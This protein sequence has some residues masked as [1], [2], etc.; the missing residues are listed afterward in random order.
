[1]DKKYFMENEGSIDIRR[2]VKAQTHYF[3]MVGCIYGGNLAY[4]FVNLFMAFRIPMGIV[5][6]YAPVFIAIEN[7]LN[8]FQP[9]FLSCWALCL[10][11]KKYF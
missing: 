1:M 10:L 7:L 2:L 8:R 11:R 3:Q 6:F 4:L 5:K 9:R